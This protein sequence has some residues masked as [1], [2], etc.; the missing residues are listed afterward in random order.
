MHGVVSQ[1]LRRLECNC[2]SVTITAGPN[3]GNRLL[4]GGGIVMASFLSV[5]EEMY[6][7]NG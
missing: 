7:S 1:R 2:L 4:D 3:V 5:L 6:P